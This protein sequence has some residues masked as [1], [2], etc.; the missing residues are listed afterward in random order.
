MFLLPLANS[1][2]ETWL[3][4]RKR[5]PK[6]IR[7]VAVVRVN[8]FRLVVALLAGWAAGHEQRNVRAVEEY[9]SISSQ[10]LVFSVCRQRCLPFCT[11][12]VL[13]VLNVFVFCWA[14]RRLVRAPGKLIIWRRFKTI[15]LKLFFFGEGA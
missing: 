14:G 6:R 8:F 11:K 2:S 13:T 4:F 10:R 15:F 1:F 9:G 5:V 7:A 3:K 12:T